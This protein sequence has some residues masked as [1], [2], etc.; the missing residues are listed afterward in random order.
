MR[1]IVTSLLALFIG[2]VFLLTGDAADVHAGAVT[3]AAQQQATE[4]VYA[5]QGTLG[6]ARNQN[7]STFMVTADGKA[8][9]L[10]G[11]TP[12]VEQQITA[13]RN[14]G[15]NTVAKVWG[16]LYPQGRVSA[17]PEIVVSNIVAANGEAAPTPAPTPSQPIATVRD[18]TI[19]LRGGPGTDYPVVGALNAGVTC[20]ISGRNAQNDWWQVGQCSTGLTGWVFQTLVD[21]TGSTSAI[22][23]VAA[24]PPPAP[25]PVPPVTTFYNWKA[26]FFPNRDLSGSAA[27]IQDVPEVNFDWGGGSPPGLPADNFS[28][29]FERTINFNPGTYR[30]RARADDGVRVFIDNQ[31]VINQ[32]NIGSANVEYTAD[33]S[34]YGNQAVRVE[35]FE[36]TG[37]ASISFNFQPLSNSSTVDGGGS[38]E[39]EANYF[40][41]TDLSGNPAL[42]RRESRSAYPLDQN[43]GNGTPAPGIIND[44]NWS[45]RWRGRFGFDSGNYVFQANVDDGVR[46]YIDGI[47]ILDNWSDGYKEVSNRFQNLGGGDHDITVEYYERGGGAMIRVWWWRESSSSSSGGSG[48][49]LPRDR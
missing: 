17:T 26:S 13:L 2:S 42:V 25:T 43:W 39:W 10:V 41:N 28:S 32:W 34:M 44:D 14:Q 35:H 23:V 31:P 8:Y 18:A 40:N 9:A 21:I 5:L 19:N 30:F 48:G 7:F 33:R 1:K 20:P 46:V 4:P 45:A 12:D 16:T 38:G 3:A 47:R 6:V 37:L 27:L 24:P 49:G 22:P 36:A 11:E 29:R 15:P